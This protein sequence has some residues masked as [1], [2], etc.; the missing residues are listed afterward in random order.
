MPT[1]RVC[2]IITAYNSSD[3]VRDTI[4]A[5][6]S[7]VDEV[8]VVDDHSEADGFARITSGVTEFPNVTVVRNPENYGLGRTLNIGVEHAN[9]KNH[10][11]ILTLDDNGNAEPHMVEKMLT[12]YGMLTTEEQKKVGII[13]PN[14]TTIKGLVYPPSP[15]RYI[16]TTITAGQ[17]VKASLFKN[18][19]AYRE[20]L[21]VGGI[22]HDFSFRALQAGYKMLLVPSAILKETPG[23]APLVRTILGKEFVVPQY[24][25]KRYYYIYRNDVYLYK[26]YWKVVPGWIIRNKLSNITSY[27]KILLFEPQKWE[28]TRMIAHGYWDGL[29]GRLG[30][31]E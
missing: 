8:I 27:I 26:K 30:K 4:R 29:H 3:E 10:E 25:A 21:I 13:A 5:I 23:P 14:Y 9:Q 16:P 1:Q 24:S 6:A 7:H 2:A 28:K 11:W 18:I 19:G 15:P 22:D 12:A 17:L 20:D 31:R